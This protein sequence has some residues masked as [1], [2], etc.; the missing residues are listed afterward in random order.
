MPA[1]MEKIKDTF[2]AKADLKSLFI[3]LQPDNQVSTVMVVSYVPTDKDSFQVFMD[4]TARIAMD[5]KTIPDNLLLHFEG[6]PAKDIPF[7]SELPA[8]DSEKALSFIASYGGITE[9]NSVPLRKAAYLRA[10]Q[11]ELTA[12]NIRDL[13]YSPAYK[14]F[15]AHEDAMEK[16]AAGKQAKQFYTIAE[17]EQGVR[18]FND[19]LSGTIK[20]RDYL[21]STADNFYSSSL[22]DVESLNIYRIETVSR[23]ML[24][25]SNGNQTTMPQAGMEI[26]ANY[27]PS[28]TFDMH[29]TG[30]NLNRFVTAGALELSIRNRNIMT[31]QD[32]AARGYAHLPADESFAYKKDFL[33]VE[34]G[35]REITR[36][37]ELYRDF[38]EMLFTH[39][40]ISGPLT[41]SA[42]SHL[43]DMKKHKY[44]AFIDL[45]PALSEEQLYD[46]ITRD[47][48]LLA[49]HAAQGALV[50]LLPS[51]MQPVM[52]ARWGI[53]PATKANQITR[54]QK[55]ELVQLVKHWQVSIDARGDLAHAVITS[56]GVSVREVDPKTMQ[57]KKAL[58]LYFAGEVLDVDAYTGG[59]N[60][61]IA[62]C[63]AQSFAN[64][65]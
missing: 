41:L 42:S 13:D 29:P 56:G 2:T 20:F 25:L 28:V 26:L 37:K 45:K 57:S 19:G 46:R 10:C 63:T 17:T 43:G 23:R 14:C 36:Q 44:E 40:G 8:K 58:G 33:F 7:T 53:D 35:I 48:A 18:V 64:N 55:R 32:I 24:E 1:W 16:I 47:F 22:Q 65:L 12:E 21:Q 61:Q 6:I 49:N 52:V 5:Q 4:L 62:F 9:N 34:K 50:K 30:E 38:G 3:V 27:K 15:I 54:E 51:S 11:R 31:L 60:L 39:F 59:Y